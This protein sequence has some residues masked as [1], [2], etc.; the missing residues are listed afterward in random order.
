VRTETLFLAAFP[1]TQVEGLR[2]NPKFRKVSR[3]ATVDQCVLETGS[4]TL[5]ILCI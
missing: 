2:L 4:K 3:M 1:M 5:I